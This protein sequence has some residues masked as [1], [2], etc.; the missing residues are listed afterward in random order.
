MST[1]YF[2]L[3]KDEKAPLTENS[4][5]QI[6]FVN[7]GLTFIL[8]EINMDY[9]YKCGLFES[10]IMEWGKQL[11][12]K[13]DVFLDIG[14]HT[15]TYALSYADYSQYVYAFEPQKMTFYA[16][17]GSVALSNKRNVSC[18][19]IG[20]GSPEQVGK[21]TL[22]IRSLDGG[23][24]SICRIAGADILAQ[25]TVPIETLDGFAETHIP[26]GQHIGLIKMDVE[27][28]ELYVLQGS[29]EI[30]RK[31][32]PKIMFEANPDGALNAE[33][34]SFLES[35]LKYKIISLTGADN[36]FLAVPAVA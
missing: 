32:Q 23:G 15:G 10:G 21:A 4:R 22:H 30:I 3:T 14:A 19:N 29:K 31:H 18:F 5:N 11:C 36:M 8:P 28:N 9:Y 24:S 7:Q 17:C 25:E 2:L 27:Y 20:L 33:L 12:S 13:N 34:F 1:P 6:L 16:L 26:E 35:T